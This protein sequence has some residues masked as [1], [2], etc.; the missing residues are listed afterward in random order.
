MKL[1]YAETGRGACIRKGV[2]EDEVYDKLLREVGTSDGV[3][4]VR[5]A[6]S[7]DIAYVKGMGGYVPKLPEE[8]RG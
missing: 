3:Q 1:F 7:R 4:G 5:E 2:D 6:T 8:Y